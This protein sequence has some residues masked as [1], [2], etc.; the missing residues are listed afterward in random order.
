VLNLYD[1]SIRAG[2]STVILDMLDASSLLWRLKLH[3]VDAGARWQSLADA[4]EPRI[5]D[6]WYAF[7]DAHAMMAFAGAG[8]DDLVQRL[9]GVMQRTA[10]LPTDNGRMTRAD[11]HERGGTG[12]P[13]TAGTGAGQRTTCDQAA[14]DAQPDVV[15]ATRVGTRGETSPGCAAADRASPTRYPGKS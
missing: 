5:D 4:W 8:R 15:A 7:N 3:G 2:N 11:A 6:A 12:R 1:R 13:V 14:V 9:L 10:S